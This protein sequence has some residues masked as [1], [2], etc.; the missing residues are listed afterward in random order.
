MKKKKQQETRQGVIAPKPLQL[1]PQAAAHNGR[2]TVKTITGGKLL[3][4]IS[5]FND[6]KA[7]ETDKESAEN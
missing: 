3:G 2:S 7:H 6:A 4:K 5:T 1:T